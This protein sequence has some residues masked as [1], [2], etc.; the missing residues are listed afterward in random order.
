MKKTLAIL[1][2]FLSAVS[3][4][5]QDR[6]LKEKKETPANIGNEKPIKTKDV[7]VQ[8]DGDKPPITDYKIISYQRD[9]TYQDTTLSI[10]KE[11]KYNYLR[12]DDYA[13][14]PFSNVGQTYTT[15]V[16]DFNEVHLKPLFGAR[17][18]HFNFMEVEDINY[19]HVPTPLTELYFKTAFEQGQ[20]L[21]AFFT[22]NTS[23]RLNLSIAYKG[24]RSLGNY[25]H[26]LTSTGNF[27][28]TTNYQSKNKRYNARA[29]IV[30]Q[31]LLNEENGGVKEDFLP[32]FINDA[33]DF[34]DRGRL[35]V[36]F[37]NAENTL[38]GKRFYLEHEYA[39]I[40]LSDSTS[41]TTLKLGNS[42]NFEDKFYQY[43]QTTPFEDFGPSYAS[44]DL[45]DRVTLRDFNSQVYAAF[46]NNLLGHVK[47]FAGYT[48]Y[49]YG[50]DS[51]LI[52]EEGRI[53]NRLKG[54]LLEAG[55]EYQKEYRGFELYGKAAI[56][57]SGDFEGNYIL[58]TASYRLNK[59]N[60]AKA[61][62]HIKSVAPNY[63]FMLYQSDYVNYNWQNSFKNI[64][65]QHLQFDLESNKLFNTSVSY[66]GIEDYTY[67]SR[68]ATDTTTTP[69]QHNE[70]VNYLKIQVDKEIA[71]GKFA[72]N[73]TLTYQE[74][75]SGE[76]VFNVPQ[77]L[78]RSSIYF[79][80]HF[81]KRAM[82]LQ[83]GIT[84]KYFTE[85]TMDAYDPV[86]AE[87]YVQNDQKL[88]NFPMVD[89][90]VNAKVS[91][92]RIFLKLEHINSIF[93]EK[94]YF[95]APG[96]PYRDWKIR[97]GLVWNFFM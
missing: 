30:F 34:R 23:E 41:Y 60:M 58:G 1:L 86:L 32:F 53:T 21:D 43:K 19:Y 50:Y 66:T 42:I 67:F 65:S 3:V 4:F 83:T 5:S 28:F 51:V 40:Q 72:W 78:G 37:E 82:F 79:S 69:F 20:Q 52:L 55:A 17:A 85:Y 94:N 49:N 6:L 88:G 33:P 27:R 29:H 26:L 9:T 13:L 63:N 54:T 61:T 76:Q 7:N 10:V 87:F 92:T 97:F 59:D 18:R 15:L 2:L 62:V 38:E 91:Q 14:M 24:V 47:V 48:D 84:A 93:G 70:R 35:E 8:L 80:D 56:N 89:F 77:L 45:L 25:Q 90:F 31:D 73:N 96:Y 11:Y 81:F 12:R 75:L 39:F 57:V 46:N 64:K 95:S 16:H 22:L 71:Y 36:N 74:V 44:T 68:N